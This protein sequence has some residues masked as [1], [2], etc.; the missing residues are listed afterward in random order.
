MHM[1]HRLALSVAVLLLLGGAL[2]GHAHTTC[3]WTIPSVAQAPNTVTESQEEPAIAL[4]EAALQSVS[5]RGQQEEV[6]MVGDPET[7]TP[8]VVALNDQ[9]DDSLPE[10]EPDSSPFQSFCAGVGSALQDTLH[11]VSPAENTAVVPVL[12]YHH[13]APGGDNSTVIS[14]ELFRAHMAALKNAGYTALFPDDLS[15]YVNGAGPLPEKPVVITFDDGYLSSYEYAYPI[16][17]EYGLVGTIF[18]IG[19]TV[20]NTE[21][22]KDTNYPITPHFSFQQG[23]EMVA[24]GVISLQSHTYDMH[25]WAPYE[26]TSRPRENILPLAGETAE[27]YRAALTADCQKIRQA[28]Q[29]GTGEPNVHAIA[30][31]SGK[32]NDLAEAVLLENGFDITFT[33]NVGCNLLIKGQPQTLLGLCRFNINQSVS[34]E[35]LLSWVSPA[36]GTP[37]VETA[38]TDLLSTE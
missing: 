3:T 19:A 36:R 28:I 15:A 12:M 14:P 35:Q 23:A 32:Y 25:Q 5:L 6:L 29:E 20:G 18:V 34:V 38:G 26:S 30:Y 11:Q 22:Y 2:L 17:K 7:T 33:I 4:D 9:T 16:L 8:Q 10:E 13:I 21:H 37:A 31:P 24:S 1:K 27:E